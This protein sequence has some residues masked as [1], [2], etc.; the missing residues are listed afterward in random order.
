MTARTI[1]KQTRKVEIHFYFAL[2][3]SSLQFVDEFRVTTTFLQFINDFFG[4]SD[5]YHLTAVRA[6][7]ESDGLNNKIVFIRVGIFDDS[8]IG[9]S[10]I[11]TAV[12]VMV[13]AHFS[14]LQP[15]LVRIGFL[16]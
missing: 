11:F 13:N 5:K 10:E 3:V 4:E 14:K 9:Q 2:P 16:D 7:K 6:V 15:R 8:Q 12:F 1:R